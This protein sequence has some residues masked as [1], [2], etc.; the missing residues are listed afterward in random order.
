MSSIYVNELAV[1]L[2]FLGL[3]ISGG[4]DEALEE[5]W[6]KIPQ[7]D[8]GPE[9]KKSDFFALGHKLYDNAKEEVERL[10]GTLPDVDESDLEPDIEPDTEPSTSEEIKIMN[11]GE[12]MSWYGEPYDK[13]R[14]P[15]CGPEYTDKAFDIYYADG[16]HLPVPNPKKMNMTADNMKYQPGGQWS[17][18]DPNIP[19]MECYAREGTHPEWCKAVFQHPV[20][21]GEVTEPD[22]ND[23]DNSGSDRPGWKKSLLIKWAGNPNQVPMPNSAQSQYMGFDRAWYSCTDHPCRTIV[24]QAEI[25]DGFLP[26]S[27][28]ALFVFSTGVEAR[29]SNTA[30]RTEYLKVTK[31]SGRGIKFVKG[32]PNHPYVYDRKSDIAFP[33]GSTAS[34][35][36]IYTN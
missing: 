6:L 21:A 17:D 11:T 9:V 29:L 14:F 4:L 18:N 5:L 33:E 23:S 7:R 20:E 30:N 8:G 13:F 25:P 36:K 31:G 10:I 28:P 26:P 35:V 16:N 19:T 34:W 1:A 2:M 32:Q 3:E 12:K 22:D 24:R 27:G 15:K